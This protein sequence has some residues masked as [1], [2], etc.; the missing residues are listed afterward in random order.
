VHRNEHA[1]E[2]AAPAAA[3][4]PFL[5]GGDERLLW[6]GALKETEQLTEGSHG[7][8]SRWRDVF[9]DHGQRIDL[10][11]ELIEYEPNERLRV[12]LVGRGFESTSTQELEERGGLTRV[13][14]VLETDYKGVAA[15]LV[16]GVVTRHA[17]S[18][19]EADLATLK[20]LVEARAES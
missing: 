14:A 18:R 17:Q 10:E 11:A 3:V 15:R 7:V 4:F 13:S 20:E 2:I 8:G 1:V 12:R 9:V 19:L 5:V 16:A 6:M